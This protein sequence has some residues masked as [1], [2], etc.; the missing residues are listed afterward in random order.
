MSSQYKTVGWTRSK[1]IYDTLLL[2]GIGLFL[3]GFFFAAERLRPVRTALDS[4]S[5]EIR[6]YGSCA[7]LLLTLVLLLGPLARLDRR[8]LPLLYNRRHFGVITCA[9][10][11]MH[12]YS[13]LGWYFAFSPLDPWTALLAMD[14]SYGQLRGFP[15]IPFGFAAF[16]V[17]LVM[18][19]TSHDFWL[20]FLTPRVWKAIHMAVY[21][22]YGSVILHVSFGALQDARNPGLPLLVGGCAAL[23]CGLHLAAAWRERSRQDIP[24]DATGWLNTGPHGLIPEGQS[25]VI[26][27]PNGKRVALFRDEG[28]F[29][30]ISNACAHQ[31]GPLGEGK[32]VKGCVICPW[33]GYE[34]RLIDGCAPAP[35]TEKVRTYRLRLSE[36]QILLDPEPRPLGEKAVPVLLPEPRHETV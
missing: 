10:A 4:Q 9:V 8:F 7:F 20:S 32:V 2:V 31:N 25:R 35:F 30:A 11:A 15:F 29:Y 3:Q 13:V 16:L 36:G 23:V 14:S 12:L 24:V 26:D 5:L 33:H 1:I 21:G 28:R 22:A 6:A 17:L 18:A 19:A 34:Y 27:L